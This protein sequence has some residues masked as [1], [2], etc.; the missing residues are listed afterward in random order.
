MSISIDNADPKE[1]ANQVLELA[2][3]FTRVAAGTDHYI[4]IAALLAAQRSAAESFPCC[5]KELGVLMVTHGL[6]IQERAHQDA[7]RSPEERAQQVP[8]TSTIQ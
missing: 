3:G 5:A 8:A 4:Y 1:I 2:L 6:A 7:A